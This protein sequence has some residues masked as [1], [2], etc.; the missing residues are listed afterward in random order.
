VNASPH[1]RAKTSPSIG[2]RF[3]LCPQA[4]EIAQNLFAPRLPL[5]PEILNTPGCPTRLSPSPRPSPSGRGR[6]AARL[7][8]KEGRLDLSKD[9]TPG[10]LSPRERAGVRGKCGH[11]FQRHINRWEVRGKISRK[12]FSEVVLISQRFRRTKMG[13]KISMSAAIFGQLHGHGR[14]EWE[15]PEINEVPLGCERRHPVEGRGKLAHGCC[16]SFGFNLP[17]AVHS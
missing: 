14:G 4:G 9:W 8:S 16:R 2:E 15:R 3:S 13:K 11:D 12:R 17:P 6:I 5:S 10:S 7:S 1:R